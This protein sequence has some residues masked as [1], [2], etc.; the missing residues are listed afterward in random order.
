MW[1]KPKPAVKADITAAELRAEFAECK[2][3]VRGL[4]L[5]WERTY[6]K[7]RGIVARMSRKAGEIEDVSPAA[8][9]NQDNRNTLPMSK[10]Q[11]GHGAP[12]IH[13]SNY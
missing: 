13:R 6:A 12:R 8:P 5:E 11:L 7:L 10:A 4:E 2:A 3:S 9:V 1:F